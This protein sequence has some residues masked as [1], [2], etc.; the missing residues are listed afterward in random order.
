MK[1]LPKSA[2]EIK[3]E[4]FGKKGWTLHTIL[5]YTK[6]PGYQELDVHAYDYWSMDA[7]QDS[8]FTAS[9]LHHAVIESLENKP[10]W[11]TIISDNG[12]HYHNTDLMMILGNWLE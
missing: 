7:C 2:K 11:I 5:I 3:A 4:F 10:K 8:W 1:I 9:S 6:K 12:P